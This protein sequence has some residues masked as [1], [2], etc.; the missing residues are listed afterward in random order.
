[1]VLSA[2]ALRDLRGTCVRMMSMSV[3]TLRVLA[4]MGELAPMPSEV[5]YAAA[6]DSG[7][8][9]TVKGAASATALLVQLMELHA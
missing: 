8:D 5:M 9:R 4:S 3:Q 2:T 6:R 7:R 1:M